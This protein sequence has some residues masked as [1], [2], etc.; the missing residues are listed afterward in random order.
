M[1]FGDLA[2]AKQKVMGTGY[3]E[4]LPSFI[5]ITSFILIASFILIKRQNIVGREKFQKI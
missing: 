2:W 1:F 4:T 3:F 5:L